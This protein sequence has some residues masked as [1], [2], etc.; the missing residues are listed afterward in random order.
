MGFGKNS[1]MNQSDHFIL[2]NTQ[3]SKFDNTLTDTER[4]YSDTN[5][6][7]ENKIYHNSTYQIDK[8][9][10]IKQYFQ[11]HTAIKGGLPTFNNH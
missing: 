6:V 7:H 4:L 9:R 10:E 5:F 8:S 2:E 11:L 3:F 1:I